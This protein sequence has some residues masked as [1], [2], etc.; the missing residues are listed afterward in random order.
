MNADAVPSANANA[1][2]PVPASIPALGLPLADDSVLLFVTRVPEL[3]SVIVIEP[4]MS[5][6][7]G[8]VMLSELKL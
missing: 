8:A 5:D 3:A 2:A 7:P 1:T 6:E 4:D